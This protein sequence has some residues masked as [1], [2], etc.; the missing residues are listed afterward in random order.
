MALGAGTKRILRQLLSESSIL[1]LLG[2]LLG[3]LLTPIPLQLIVSLS[4]A[5]LPRVVSTKIDLGALLC[6]Q[7]DGWLFS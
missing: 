6:F 3:L 7:R 2:G 4:A 5:A 1:S